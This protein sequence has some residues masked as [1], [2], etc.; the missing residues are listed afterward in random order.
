MEVQEGMVQKSKCQC[1][2]HTA[3]RELQN[4]ESYVSKCQS[5]LHT[6]IRELQNVESYVS[7]FKELF[8]FRK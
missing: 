5:I 2:L 1:I 3:I 4:V 6:A 8:Q 7:Y